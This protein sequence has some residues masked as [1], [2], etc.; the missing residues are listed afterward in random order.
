MG[1]TCLTSTNNILAIAAMS[2]YMHLTKQQVISLRN[3]LLPYARKLNGFL[4][5]S[6]VE[7][8]SNVVGIADQPDAT[9]VSLLF[10]MWDMS[11]SGKVNYNDFVV[12]LSVLACENDTYEN[13]LR[14]ALDVMDVKRTGQVKSRDAFTVLKSELLRHLLSSI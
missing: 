6:H 7:Y 12:G 13:A 3:T 8:A 4:R 10:T 11:G 14:F 9:I 1:N 5:R 2:K